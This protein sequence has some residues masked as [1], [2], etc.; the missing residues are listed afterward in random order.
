M[1]TY[2]YEINE[3]YVIFTNPDEGH[4]EIIQKLFENPKN[5]PDALFTFKIAVATVPP[6]RHK[7]KIYW[8]HSRRYDTMDFPSR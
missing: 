5:R 2:D 7:Q 1:K 8:A 3:D 4:E 6:Y